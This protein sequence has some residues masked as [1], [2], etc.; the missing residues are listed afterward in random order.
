MRTSKWTSD[1]Y[2]K[3]S[4]GT[5]DNGSDRST[6]IDKIKGYCKSVGQLY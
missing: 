3:R 1:A 4:L 5:L 6:T 2:F